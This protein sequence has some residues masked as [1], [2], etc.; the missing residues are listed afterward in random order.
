M[1]NT[2]W[3]IKL[4]MCSIV[5]VEFGEEV[6]KILLGQLRLEWLSG[7]VVGREGGVSVTNPQAF[8]KIL[9][10]QALP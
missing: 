8:V 10:L 2:S 4:L 9:A 1:P 7:N 6:T 5:Q 3:I